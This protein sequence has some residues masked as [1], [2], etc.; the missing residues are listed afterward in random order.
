M[1]RNSL[2]DTCS[3]DVVGLAKDLITQ[4]TIRA[5]TFDKIMDALITR[6]VQ[7][8]SQLSHRINF[9]HWT[10]EPRDSAMEFLATLFKLDNKYRFPN[11]DDMLMASFTW[12]QTDRK[13]TLKVAAAEEITLKKSLAFAATADQ[14]VVNH[15]FLS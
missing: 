1:K 7:Q 10:R 9:F 3:T 13:L 12:V 11:L 6:F 8:P 14:S 2:L 5:T 4:K 15:Q